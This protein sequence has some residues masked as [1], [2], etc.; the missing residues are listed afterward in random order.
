MIS[1]INLK[2]ENMI[3]V[4]MDFD[5]TI[6]KKDTFIEFIKFHKSSFGF[7][8]GFL[9]LLPILIAFKLGVIPNWKAKEIVFS[10][11]FK[12]I[13]EKKLQTS[14]IKFAQKVLPKLIRK[15]ALTEIE[16]FK[17]Q[18]ARIVVVTASFP[19]WIKPWCD[20]F[21]I[22][23]IATDFE[24]RDDKITGKITGRNCFGKEKV[25][26]IKEL[27]NI[28]EVDEIFAY[29]DSKGDYEM[30]NIAD[31]KYYKWRKIG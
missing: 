11:F 31:V 24:V 12:N 3:L 8:I 6:T 5:G 26:R 21:N 22:E 7:Y 25:R 30:L 28:E 15:E 2:L 29:G 20:N 4:L 14:G 19:I 17:E 1:D 23:L 18:H 13:E 9:I 27:C 10:F 16:R